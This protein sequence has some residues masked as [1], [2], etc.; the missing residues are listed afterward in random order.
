MRLRRKKPAPAPVMDEKLARDI[1][2][3]NT[4]RMVWV[5]ARFLML[6]SLTFVIVYPVLFMLSMSLRSPQDVF[7]PTVVWI[8]KHF[9]LENFALVNEAV[10]F[11]ESLKN[12]V[13]IA[14]GAS[15][16]NVG[17]CAFTGYGLAR[18]RIYGKPFFIVM[19]LFMIIVPQQM[20]SL[21][22]Y[23]LFLNVDFFG[24][25]EAILGH[26]TGLNLIDNPFGFYLLAALGMGIRSGLFII[27]FMQFFKG[28]QQEIE[29]AALVDGCGFMRIF[30]RIMLPNAAN[31]LIVAFLFSLV[32]YWNDYY[33]AAIYIPTVPTLATALANI[34]NSLTSVMQVS[35]AA[36]DPYRIITL[37][38]AACLMTVAPL[39]ILYIFTQRFFT[40]SIER[41]GLVG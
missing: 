19:V 4:G 35:S 16:L 3:S 8:P 1:L 7:D 13:L 10:K 41:S 30:F 36:F 32:W 18:F 26:P 34:Q 9:T 40:E 29:N 17:V 5:V 37:Q 22:N 23:L 21:P 12:T 20:L 39:L 38:Q 24:L 28:M 31:I 6:L 14:V 27:I 15:L 11:L 33:Q 2:V 25:F